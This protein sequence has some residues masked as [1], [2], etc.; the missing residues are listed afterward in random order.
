M[1]FADGVLDFQAR[2]FKSAP[3]S[4]MVPLGIVWRVEMQ[5]SDTITAILAC[6]SFAFL[7]AII[8]G[9]F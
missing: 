2:R 8:I 9:V 4:R 3:E 5:M 6:A 7:V 1:R